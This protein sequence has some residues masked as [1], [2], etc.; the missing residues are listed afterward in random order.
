[1]FQGSFE[2]SLDTKGRVSLPAK[3]RELL[4]SSGDA[5]LIITTNVDAGA[6]CLWAYPVREWQSF[7]E[8]IA[9]LPQLDEAVIRLKRLHIAGASDCSI[10]R[11]GRILIPPMLREYA[12]LKNQIIFAGVGDKI[13]IWDKL[14]WEAERTRAKE[15]LPEINASIARLGL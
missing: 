15:N 12:E 1:M 13:E 10:D 6:Q 3:F 5:R 11:Q 8:R 9:G 4:T 14:Q 7:H 2:H